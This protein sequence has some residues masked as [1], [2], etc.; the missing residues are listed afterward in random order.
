MKVRA[1]LRLLEQDGWRVVRI[2]GSHR[3]LK[4]A[5]KPG[6]VTIAGKPGADVPPGTL[7]AILKHARLQPPRNLHA[8]RGSD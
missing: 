5:A 6:T 2:R 4:H 8:L 7:R 3:Q 1:L